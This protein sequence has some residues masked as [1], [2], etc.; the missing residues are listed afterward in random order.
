MKKSVFLCVIGCLFAVPLLAQK[1]YGGYI[2]R[3]TRI[4]LTDAPHPPNTYRFRAVFYTEAASQSAFP[5]NL[6]FYLCRKKDNVR[7]I[8]FNATKTIYTEMYVSPHPCNV[9]ENKELSIVAY[10]FEAILKPDDYKDP[11]GYY[12]CSEPVCCLSTA[13]QNISNV[14]DGMVLYYEFMAPSNGDVGSVNFEPALVQGIRGLVFA[15]KDKQLAYQHYTAITPQVPA[16]AERRYRLVNPLTKGS[17]AQNFQPAA[18]AAG[19]SLGSPVPSAVPLTV[20]GNNLGC[21][22]S[23]TP[24]QGG[25]NTIAFATDYYRDNKLISTTYHQI[26]LVV[27][28]CESNTMPIIVVTKPGIS[29]ITPP[30]ICPGEQIQL[31]ARTSNK[32]ATFRWRLNGRDISNASADSVQLFNQPGSYTVV[33]VDRNRC[34]PEVTSMPVTITVLP[35]PVVSITTSKRAFCEGD[36][37]SLSVNTNTGWTY[38]WVLDGKDITGANQTQLTAKQSG[39]Y[40]IKVKDANCT[41]SAIAVPITQNPFPTINAGVDIE[42]VQG[43]SVPLSATSTGA[44]TY[45]WESALGLDRYNVLNPIA[46]PTETTTYRIIATSAAGCAAS[47]EITIRVVKDLEIPSAFTP[48]DD[49]VNDAWTIKGIENYPNCLVDVFDRWGSRIYSSQGYG[50]PWDGKR[51]NELMPVATYYFVINLNLQNREPVRGTIT[52]VK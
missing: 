17:G 21:I 52:I 7:L 4:Q 9:S 47:D 3:Y 8:T 37:A 10:L 29:M 6:T 24:S 44:S 45:R 16:D 38:Q 49:G 30:V 27:V 43:A 26:Q 50:T 11:E 39:S 35:A 23:G 36:S 14:K 25:D 46:N 42:I 20:T 28:E 34:D 51:Q 15:C 12:V 5:A 19:L 1:M 2:E 31:I 32:K 48:N 41:S 33:S 22:I 18:W 40:S 13:I